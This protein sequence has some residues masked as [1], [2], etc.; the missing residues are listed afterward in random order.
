MLLRPK[1]HNQPSDIANLFSARTKTG[2]KLD[3]VCVIHTTIVALSSTSVDSLGNVPQCCDCKILHHAQLELRSLA[4][5]FQLSAMELL[6][7]L[8]KAPFKGFGGSAMM[9][10]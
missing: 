6:S 4:H 7:C 3:L 9:R 10:S 1:D 2:S 5:P 8:Y